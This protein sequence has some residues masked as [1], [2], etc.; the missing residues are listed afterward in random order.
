MTKKEQVAFDALRKELALERAMRYSGPVEPDVEK[1]EN[2]SGLAKG[3]A[4]HAWDLN[5]RIEKGATTSGSH[6][7]GESAW[8]WSRDARS[9]SQQSIPLYSTR[10]LALLAARHQIWL[11][12]QASLARI[13]AEIEALE[14]HP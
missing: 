9:G 11:N 4:M 12:A 13:D 10:A 2:W 5:F 14:N 7:T 1:P 3:W 8:E 6:F